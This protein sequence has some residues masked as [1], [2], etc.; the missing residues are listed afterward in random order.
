MNYWKLVTSL[1]FIF[2]SIMV[3]AKIYTPNCPKQ[4]NRI[5]HINTAHDNW[6]TISSIPN[7]FLSGVS[8]YSGHPKEGASLKPNSINKKVSKWTFSRKQRIYI[9][10]EY[11]QTGIKLTQPLAKKTSQCTI[12]YNPLVQSTNGFLPEKIQCTQ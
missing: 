2:F 7:N 4:I 12:S 9:V 8:F 11:N 1:Y 3:Q 10:C 5:E 6:E